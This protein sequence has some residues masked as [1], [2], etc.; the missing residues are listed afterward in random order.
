MNETLKTLALVLK[1]QSENKFSEID[2]LLSDCDL[3]KVT[4]EEMT[5]LLR[6]N[7]PVR[8]MLPT[9]LTFLEKAKIELLKRKLNAKNIL[10]GLMEEI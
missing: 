3:E 10:R 6:S 7:Y 4:P 5:V 2:S 8:R 9:W 1:L